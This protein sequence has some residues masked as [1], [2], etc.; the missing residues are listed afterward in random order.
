[1]NK[2]LYDKKYPVPEEIL[3]NIEFSLHK[4]SGNNDGIKRAKFIKNNKS[5]TYQMLKGLKNFFDHAENI[6]NK[7]QYE[8]AGGDLMKQWVDLTLK[9]ER[10]KT[11]KKG[12][13]EIT[14]SKD[15]ISSLRPD[16]INTNFSINENEEKLNEYVICLLFNSN[17][18]ILML[19][20]GK[21]DNWMPNKWAFLGGTIEKNELPIN[22][23]KR[24]IKEE[25]GVTIKK[26]IEKFSI[27]RDN[28]NEYI[29]IGLIQ[30]DDEKNIKLDEE[31]QDFKFVSIENLSKLDAVPNVMDYIRI[32]LGKNEYIGK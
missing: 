23:A 27:K 17:N 30:Q 11:E 14:A 4:Y 20:R 1:M 28:Q 26:L 22:A 12:Y 8:L 21:T 32:V 16:K 10:A 31:N 29:Y 19:K 6:K 15:N 7:E 13:K 18:D 9:N 2:Q 24:E 3:K 25:I 5:C